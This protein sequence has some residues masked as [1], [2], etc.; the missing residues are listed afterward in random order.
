[1]LIKVKVCNLKQIFN[2]PPPLIHIH[3]RHYQT[4]TGKEASVDTIF[5][6]SIIKSEDKRYSS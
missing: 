4:L 1:M 2:I 6:L 5:L 3:L